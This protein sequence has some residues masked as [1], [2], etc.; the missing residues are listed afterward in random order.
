[1]RDWRVVIPPSLR[2]E[3]IHNNHSAHQGVSGMNG[4]VRGT[5]YWPGISEEI[6]HERDSCESCNRYAP[7]QAKLPSHGVALSDY[8]FQQIVTD[9]CNY[10]GH[11][12]IIVVDRFSGWL[13]VYHCPDTTNS[14]H[15]IN[16]LR[17]HF[18]IYGC[19]EELSSDR[20]SNYISK[21]TSDFLKKWGVTQR[22]S[23]IY[24]PHTNMR[25]ETGV[26]S[27]KRMLR[28]NILPNGSLDNDK[29]G[30]ASLQYKNTP[31]Q[32]LGKSP[33]QIVYGCHLRD[34]TPS[35]VENLE[36]HDEWRLSKD[37]RER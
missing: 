28:E 27:A 35:D 5:I 23:S 7:T 19:S 36:I 1:M 31:I 24:N 14:R 20:G 11:E 26:K 6:S 8:P 34:F 30:M 37:E 22:S 16:I 3:M 12:Y 17:T 18:I 9:V 15:V 33:A 2:D 25:S 4:R 21:L 13:S 32:S 29:F 10:G